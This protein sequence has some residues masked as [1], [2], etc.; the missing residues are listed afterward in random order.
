MEKVAINLAVATFRFRIPT[1]I[2]LKKS[3][4][5]RSF[6][7]AAAILTIGTTAFTMQAHNIGQTSAFC[8]PQR[9]IEWPCPGI[10]LDDIM[11]D[12]VGTITNP[13]TGGLTP[14]IQVGST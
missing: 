2:M 5:K 8:E 6:L 4:I 11:L 12:I 1:V 7:S 13:C 10:P 3:F 14:H 9:D